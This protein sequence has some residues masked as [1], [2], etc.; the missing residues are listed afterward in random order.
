MTTLVPE[1]ALE[2]ASNPS[3]HPQDLALLLM[4]ANQQVKLLVAQNPATT[5]DLITLLCA[6]EDPQVHRAAWDRMRGE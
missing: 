4:G 2:A 6:S 3:T 1:Q 5:S